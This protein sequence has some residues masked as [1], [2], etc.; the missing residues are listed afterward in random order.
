VKNINVTVFVL[1]ILLCVFLISCDFQN[2]IIKTWW[3]EE[4]AEE[5]DF[6]YVVIT[7]N[8][9]ILVYEIIIET[10]YIYETVFEQL[11]PEIQIVYVDRPVPPEILLQHITIINIEFIIFAGNAH[12]FNGGPIGGAVSNLTPEERTHNT[13]IIEDVV[14]EMRDNPEYMLILH[15]HANPTI[16]PGQPGYEL[17]LEELVALS[18]SRAN[19]VRQEVNSIYGPE[20]DVDLANRMTARGYGGGRNISGSSSTYA[21]LNR[22]V[23]VILFTVETDPTTKPISP[24]IGK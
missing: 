8:I 17:E 6:N 13:F 3:V 10:E 1:M 2:P 19:A 18:T 11:P 23:E 5:E 20:A 7:K 21:G 4:E 12:D 24:E 15:G 14:E 9:P 16:A 22:R